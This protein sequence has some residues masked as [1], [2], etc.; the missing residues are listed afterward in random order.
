[1]TTTKL[2]FI[3][4]FALLLTSFYGA[5]LQAQNAMQSSG[6]DMKNMKSEMEQM[7][8]QMEQIQ[9]LMKDTMAKM[10]AAD[11]AM[12]SHMET[13]Q[14]SMKSQMELQQ[15]MINHLQTMTDH[16]QTHMQMMTD[17]MAMKPDP[18]DVHKKSG[19]TKQKDKKMMDD[20]KK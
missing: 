15:A 12:K 4:I 20:Q 7:R 16:M 6:M 18:M 2:L 14:A 11:A 5:P 3:S 1:M 9:T 8:A 17:R 13:E 10:A 19:A